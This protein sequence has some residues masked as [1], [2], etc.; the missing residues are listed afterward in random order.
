MPAT[1][2]FHQLKIIKQRNL[3]TLPTKN[4]CQN[5]FQRIENPF[6]TTYINILRLRNFYT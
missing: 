2:K 6:T 3:E 4:F 5:D 1:K